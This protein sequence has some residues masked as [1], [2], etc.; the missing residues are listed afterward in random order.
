MSGR[1]NPIFSD[2]YQGPRWTYGGYNRPLGY[3]TIPD[4][5]IIGS[6]Q[7]HPDY[8]HGTIDYPREL[9]A[10][11]IYA[12]ELVFVGSSTGI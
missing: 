1:N 7:P 12:Y 9:S 8:R 5:Q 3:A 10:K 4:G 6:N 11:E 2:T